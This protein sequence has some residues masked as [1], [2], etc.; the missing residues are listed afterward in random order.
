MLS[1]ND[2]GHTV[3]KI[4]KVLGG[5]VTESTKYLRVQEGGA[6]YRFTLCVR[7]PKKPSKAKYGF[8]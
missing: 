1:L 6:I 5:K 3:A 8:G 4:L 2:A 7:L